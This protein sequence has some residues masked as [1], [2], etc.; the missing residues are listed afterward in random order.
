MIFVLCF[1]SSKYHIE[2]LSY[3]VHVDSFDVE[4]ARNYHVRVLVHFL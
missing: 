1:R 3:S 2:L 4:V